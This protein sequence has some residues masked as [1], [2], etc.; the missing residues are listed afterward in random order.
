[1]KKIILLALIVTLMLLSMAACTGG[2]L[3]EAVISE[4]MTSE[5]EETGDPA[6]PLSAAQQ[7]QI[8]KDWFLFVAEQWGLKDSYDPAKVRIKHYLGTYNGSIAL[9][10]DDAYMSVHEALWDQEVAGF[11]FHN[12]DGHFISVWN[13]GT[14][15]PLPGAYGQGLLTEQDVGDILGY[16]QQALPFM[17]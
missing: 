14:F 1:M 2:G 11:V 15:Y 5:P 12:N 9:M 4:A 8:K 3:S 16:H 13:N 7:K 17:Y 6:I 10:M